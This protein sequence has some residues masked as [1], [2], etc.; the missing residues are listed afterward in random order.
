MSRIDDLEHQLAELSSHYRS[1]LKRNTM[2][3]RR[4]DNMFRFGKVTDVDHKKH[5]MRME[6]ASKDGKPIK[7]PWR[8]Y[9]QF[10]GSD[11]QDDEGGQGGAG[12]G[13]QGGSDEGKGE[14]KVHTPVSK[15]QQ[16]MFISPSGEARQGMAIPFTWHEKAKA[17]S[18]EEH[19]VIT[20]GK[21]KFTVKKEQV[22][23]KIGD[24]TLDLEKD[25]ATLKIG[26]GT[27]LTMTKDTTTFKNTNHVFEGNLLLGG[28]GA[29]R[30]L[31]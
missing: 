27:A 17:P 11:N 14:L 26:D 15:G 1:L 12:G 31:V 7:S 8:P 3:E 2:L 23:A 16:M 10:G 28:A 24:T 25:K 19:P 5:L 9:A 4:M 18:E 22:T 29:N 30:E 6:I 20:I 21:V 13:G